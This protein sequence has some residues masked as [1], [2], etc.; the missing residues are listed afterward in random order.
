MRID[1]S[2]RTLIP[3]FTVSKD[4]HIKRFSV[5][6]YGITPDDI[7]KGE[8]GTSPS[9]CSCKRLGF[10]IHDYSAYPNAVKEL[11]DALRTG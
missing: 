8:V 3:M 2:I 9:K 7:L 10:S 6:V 4:A 1:Y 11:G 5:L